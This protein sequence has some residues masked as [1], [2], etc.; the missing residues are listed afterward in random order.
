MSELDNMQTMQEENALVRIAKGPFSKFKE[1]GLAGILEEIFGRL[2]VLRRN[3]RVMN[4]KFHDT[5]DDYA[6]FQLFQEYEF[7]VVNANFIDVDQ[8]LQEN[9][10]AKEFPLLMIDTLDAWEKTEYQPMVVTIKLSEVTLEDYNKSV[11]RSGEL[12]YIPVALTEGV[13]VFVRHDLANDAGVKG[14]N[15]RNFDIIFYDK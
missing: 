12:G 9:K 7:H 4:I 2:G 5:M 6:C 3:Q 8:V 1:D 14:I 11:E 10:F 15:R 13:V